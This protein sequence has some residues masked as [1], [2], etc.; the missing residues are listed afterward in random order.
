MWHYAKTSWRAN[1]VLKFLDSSRDDAN[2]QGTVVK[3][4]W[5]STKTTWSVKTIDSPPT[6]RTDSDPAY[7]VMSVTRNNI[8]FDILY[9]LYYLHSKLSLSLLQC[10]FTWVC[11]RLDFQLSHQVTVFWHTYVSDHWLI[12]V[13]SVK[14]T[15]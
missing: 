12:S 4:M 3:T 10:T 8:S 9:L 6:S 2:Q 7:K 13:R 15:N 11:Q 14:F 1:E 5:H